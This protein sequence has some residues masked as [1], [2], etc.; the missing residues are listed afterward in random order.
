MWV[1]GKVLGRKQALF[2]D[3]SI[4]LSPDWSGDAGLT[5]RQLIARIV[6]AE[7]EGFRQ[8]QIDRQMFRTLTARQI[9]QAAETGRIEMGG[10][11]VGLQEVDTDAAIGT[12]L[13]AF[14][15]GLYLVVIDGD[16]Q[17]DLDRQVFLN[18]ESRIV[19]VRLTLL[20]GG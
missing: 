10:S 9:D 19:F 12:A 18:E 20:A 11:E 6:R 3:W 14:E 5:L 16:E 15:D 1:S 13:Q 4:P 8:R 17:R 7:V 2:A